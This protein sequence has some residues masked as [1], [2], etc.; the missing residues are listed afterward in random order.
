MTMKK[1]LASMALSV[2]CVT[3]GFAQAQRTRSAPAADPDAL[4][5][6]RAWAALAEN[7]LD[8]AT[9]AAEQVAGRSAP[10]AHEAT[11]LLIRVEAGRDRVKAALAAYERWLRQAGR[12][13]RFLLHPIAHR[14]LATL[15]RASDPAVRAAATA[16]L[17]RAGLPA[18]VA[19]NDQDISAIAARAEGGDKAAQQQLSQLV[20]TDAASVRVGTVKALA[21]AGTAAVPQLTALL[22]HRTPDVRA[23]AVEALGNIGGQQTVTALQGMR[24]DPDP[25]VR[26][27]VTV[28]LAQAGDQDAMASVTTALA[29]P[30]ADIRLA[31]AEA[32]RN[33]P[34]EASRAAVRSALGEAN[35]L[36]RA[37]AAAMLGESEEGTR[38]LV[39]LLNS[40]NPTVREVAAR[41]VED[42]FSENIGI[43]RGLLDSPDQW[44]Q[45]YG[46]GALLSAPPR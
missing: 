40:E 10:L 26:L 8:E 43:I 4:Q 30:V 44:L 18:N 16:R 34:T 22:A 39:D 11:G 23:A 35:P 42:R 1:I 38:T 9:A 7:R 45:L 28:A 13:D 14:V 32:F 46:A 21:S 5:M 27:R 36:T 25:N 3:V 12:D 20:T 37:R 17:I 15:S 33:N 29:S 19:A 24:N 31:A 6:S 41:T 2:A